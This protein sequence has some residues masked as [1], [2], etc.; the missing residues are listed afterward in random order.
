M[1]RRLAVPPLLAAAA[2]VYA[3]GAPLPHL[4]GT[5]VARLRRGHTGVAKS[6]ADHGRPTPRHHAP[7]DTLV[8]AA[9][10]IRT[11]D[12]VEFALA[13]ENPSKHRVELSFPDGRT[14][15]FAVYDASGREVWR[16]S[17]GRMF[18]QTMQ[19]KLIAAED[20]VV[21][22][23]RWDAA[24]PGRYTLVAELRSANYPIVKRAAF[25]VPALPAQ[26]AAH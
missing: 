4:D 19:N 21:Y 18:T 11:V 1:D 7:G 22:A 10:A 16:W 14:R 12:G 6:V 20:S 15:D 24:R 17:R 26:V 25:E 5:P 8:G 3:C 23:E 9:L 2:V 13:I